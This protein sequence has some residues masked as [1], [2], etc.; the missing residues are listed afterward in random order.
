MVRYVGI[1]VGKARCRAAL[2]NQTGTIEKEFFFENNNTGIANLVSTLTI[3]DKVVMEST[4]NLWLNLYD[5]LDQ[6]S[7]KV[8]LAN[9]LKTKAI[10]SAKVKTDKLDA[11][12]LA[13]LLRADLVAESYVP[14]GNVREM[15]A[16]VR[17]RLS[18]VQM[19]TMVKNKIHAVIDK[20]GYRCECSD[21]FGKAGTM[22][23]RA[24]ELS[25]LDRLLLENHLSLIE[26]INLQI[27]RVDDAIRE[28]A[29][30][31]E[32]V[33]LLLSLTGVDVYTALLLRSE[34]GP[35]ERFADYKRLVSWAGLAPSVYQSGNVEF[36]GRITKR[37]SSILRWALVEAAHIAVQR[38]ERM[39]A[40]YLRVAKRRGDQKA[41][42]AVACKML[43]IVWF[44]LTRRE[45]YGNVN[46][47][48]YEE[49]L[50]RMD[51]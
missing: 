17:H 23:L 40:F 2:M 33:R 31:D 19:R 42:V 10:A 15:R 39:K 30:E 43:K 11:I 25:A 12:I 20:Y 35:I 29:C 34:I 4:G 45:A 47:K 41:A 50:K 49:K 46:E 7:I 38:D 36:H 18:L 5:S 14:P 6:R 26:S 22:W 28:R 1:D 13:H 32:D 8:V 51:A 24:L 44:M 48:R 16:L 3:E 27:R 9:P 37:G 21:M